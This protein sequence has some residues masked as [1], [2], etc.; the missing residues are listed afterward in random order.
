MNPF[1]S[2]ILAAIPP[3]VDA[4]Y[5]Y[6]KKKVRLPLE[7][8]IEYAISSHLK[9]CNNW[10][11]QITFFGMSTP[12]DVDCN[13]IPLHLQTTPRRFR[14]INSSSCVRN[15]SFLIEDRES[16]L[17]LGDPG[18]GKTTTIKRLFTSLLRESRSDKDSYS[19]PILVRIRDL[20]NRET[21]VKR[22]LVIMGFA[23]FV[24]GMKD[25]SL[26]D[27]KRALVCGMPASDLAAEFLERL[28][29][30]L[31]V[32]G[33]DESTAENRR[34]YID[35]IEELSH[36][37]STSK[38]VATCRSGDY[39][40]VVEGF[41][42]LEIMPLDASQIDEIAES[43]LG[44]DYVT[45]NRE[46]DRLPYN[47]LADRPLIL[48]QLL[49]LFKNDGS[50]PEQPSS[51]YQRIVSLLLRDWDSTR[52]I[53]R[54]SKYAFFT[55]DKKALFLSAISFYM[56]F[57]YRQRVL[58]KSE[59]LKIY[60]SVC[61]D[62]GLPLEDG[63]LVA[64]EIESHTGLIVHSGFDNIEFSHLSIQE[65]LCADYIVKSPFTETVREYFTSYPEVLA[66]AV[67]ISSTPSEWIANLVLN[68]GFRDVVYR[69]K[70]DLAVAT[71]LRRLMLER[72]YFKS[73]DRLGLAFLVLAEAMEDLENDILMEWMKSIPVGSSI[74]SVFRLYAIDKDASR[75]SDMYVLRM[76]CSQFKEKSYAGARNLSVR[77]NIINFILSEQEASIDWLDKD[78]LTYPFKLGA[79]KRPIWSRDA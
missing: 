76:Q 71:F 23:S 19:C 75:A 78:G 2:F 20:G 55:P 33:L 77:K 63:V 54:A 68:L 36:K 43:W 51:I 79:R 49:F 24:D 4:V 61:E 30:V 15:E 46:I 16:F 32:D 18:A 12:I 64:Q 67:S 31:F 70:V 72:P 40:N 65:Y 56:T 58:V 1:L 6:N 47:D 27:F 28:N 59:F 17:L 22:L 35:E 38:I 37:I 13:T 7:S 62:F 8:D 34:V 29:C 48:T 42:V 26:D 66:L 11:R 5:R 39:V 45:F 57:E 52:R 41:S 3:V 25:V 14:R 9:E 73:C 50:F 69:S 10:A 44:D 21:V 74:A 60:S 53:K